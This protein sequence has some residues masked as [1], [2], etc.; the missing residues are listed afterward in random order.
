MRRGHALLQ[1]LKT[2]HTQLNLQSPARGATLVI[3]YSAIGFGPS[4]GAKV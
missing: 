4:A 3:G 1:I 2:I